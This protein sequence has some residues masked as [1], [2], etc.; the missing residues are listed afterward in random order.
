MILLC[1]PPAAAAGVKVEN[2]LTVFQGAGGPDNGTDHGTKR[3]PH[4]S[5][6]CLSGD[7]LEC[8]ENPHSRP[9]EGLEW[10]FRLTWATRLL[11]RDSVFP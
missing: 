10:G 6:F 5:L 3:V 2:S 1:E 8:D 4:S 9:E 7:F 11:H